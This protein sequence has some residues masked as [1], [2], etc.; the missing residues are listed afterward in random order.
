MS[1]KLGKFNRYC[2]TQWISKLPGSFEIHWVTVLFC[3]WNWN[4]LVQ[5]GLNT[6]AADALAP[7]IVSTSAAMKL[8]MPVHVF[9]MFHQVW[10]SSNWAIWSGDQSLKKMHIFIFPN[11][12]S[13]LAAMKNQACGNQNPPCAPLLPSEDPGSL[14]F[15]GWGPE[16]T[17]M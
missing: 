13:K 3:C 10:I 2:L 15:L 12:S 16:N 6:M 8:N 1:A 14:M 7:C 11:I 5:L 17:E 9:Y 4:I